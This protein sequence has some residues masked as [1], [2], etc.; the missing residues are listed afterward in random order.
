MVPFG[1]QHKEHRKTGLYPQFFQNGPL[2][3]LQF[4]RQSIDIAVDRIAQGE[5]RKIAPCS[6]QL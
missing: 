2:A 3:R 1:C 6:Y 4:L 5:R